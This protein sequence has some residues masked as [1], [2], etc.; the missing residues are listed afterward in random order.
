MPI[1]TVEWLSGR[2]ENQKGAIAQAIT[3][4]LGDIAAVEAEHV[5]V[6]FVDVQPENWAIGGRLQTTRD[7]EAADQNPRR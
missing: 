1:V 3:Q 2:N 5:W 7:D 4:T 6:R